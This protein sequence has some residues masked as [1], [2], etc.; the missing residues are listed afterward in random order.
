MAKRV[1]VK[2]AVKRGN[3]MCDQAVWHLAIVE[4]VLHSRASELRAARAFLVTVVLLVVHGSLPGAVAD[5]GIG[6]GAIPVATDSVGPT[7]RAGQSY[8]ST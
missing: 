6:A 5:L 8:R 7:G 2:P 3:G 4:G 1:A